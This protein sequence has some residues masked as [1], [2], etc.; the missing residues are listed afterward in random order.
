MILPFPPLLRV[1]AKNRI[2][3]TASFATTWLACG[4]ILIRSI[5]LHKSCTKRN[6]NFLADR[7]RHHY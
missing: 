5:G 3:P 7:S 6:S 1:R 2:R 4:G